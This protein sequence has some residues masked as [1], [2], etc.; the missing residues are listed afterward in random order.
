LTLQDLITPL[1]RIGYLPGEIRQAQLR[2]LAAG[3]ATQ[4]VACSL[5]AVTPRQDRA[6][7]P[8]GRPGGWGGPMHRGR[9]IYEPPAG[10]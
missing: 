6:A 10:Y 9:E 5:R 4:Q 3:G 8:S 2:P 1:K 7:V